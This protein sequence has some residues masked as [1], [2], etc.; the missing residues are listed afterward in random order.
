MYEDQTFEVLM[1]RMLSRVSNDID[2]REGS[3]IW[4]FLAPSALEFEQAYQQLDLVINW[5]FANQDIPRELLLSK[6]ADVG[7]VPKDAVPASGYVSFTGAEGT[8]ISTGIR[9]STTGDAPIYFYVL[10]EATIPSSGSVDVLVEA[11]T[12]GT[13]GNVP[14]NSITQLISFVDGVVSITNTS[15]FTSGIQEEPDHLLYQRYLERISTPSS[16]GNDADYIRWAKEVPGIGYARVFRT[17]NGPGTVRVVIGTYDKRSPSPVLVERVRQNILEKAPDLATITVG[18]VEELSID[19]DVK[20]SLLEDT[21]VTSTTEDIK[22][23]TNEYFYEINFNQ[24][25]IRYNKIAEAILN[26]ERVIDYEDLRVNNKTGNILLEKD[27]IA[28]LGKINII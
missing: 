16:S 6:C 20:L 4:D 1:E 19:I 15:D 18:G 8:V 27:Q 22:T 3:V 14:A 5:F 26:A 10:E 24:D 9:M 2:K 13:I 21:N 23:H 25:L 12:G 7:I 11:E 28:I 17:W